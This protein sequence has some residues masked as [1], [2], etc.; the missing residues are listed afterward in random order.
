M[1]EDSSS[2]LDATLNAVIMPAVLVMLEHGTSSISV[3]IEGEVKVLIIDT[4]CNILI[5]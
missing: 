5:L 2:R 4:S 3:H 1:K